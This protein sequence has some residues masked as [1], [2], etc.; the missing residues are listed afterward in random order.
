MSFAIDL[1]NEKSEVS[2]ETVYKNILSAY[3]KEIEKLDSEAQAHFKADYEKSKSFY[4]EYK[5]HVTFEH[6]VYLVA[7]WLLSRFSKKAEALS[8][9]NENTIIKDI[10]AIFDLIN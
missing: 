7:K 1:L 6:E 5:N 10:F 9:S 2:L 8:V 4:D 3:K